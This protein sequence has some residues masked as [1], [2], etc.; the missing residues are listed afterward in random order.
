MSSSA[1]D[2]EPEREALESPLEF[3]GGRF[4]RD[5]LLPEVLLALLSWRIFLLPSLTNLVCC[6]CLNSCSYF[7]FCSLIQF[8]LR[9]KKA[10]SFL[11][12]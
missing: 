3:E 8:C 11:A 9:A 12:N 10:C 6:I 2:L 5:M 1:F 7:M 4:F